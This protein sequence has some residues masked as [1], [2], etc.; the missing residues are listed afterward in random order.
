MDKV[1]VLFIG[2]FLFASALLLGAINI[3]GGWILAGRK[4][5]LWIGIFD[6]FSAVLWLMILYLFWTNNA[7]N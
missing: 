3:F 6:I 4:S 7:T 2:V 5:A 1:P